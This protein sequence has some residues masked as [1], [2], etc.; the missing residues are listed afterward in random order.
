MARLAPQLLGESAD[1]VREF[2]RGRVDASGGFMDRDDTADL[3]Y[4]VFGLEG[5]QALGSAPPVERVDAYLR[6]LGDGEGFDLVNLASLARAWAALG[7]EIPRDLSANLRARLDEQRR[8]GSGW[9]LEA[10]E[11][12][13]SVYSTFLAIGAYQDLGWPIEEPMAVADF[14]ASSALPD[15]GYANE[16]GQGVATT[17]T[18]VAA[19]IA[20]LQLGAAASP[21]SGRWLR[22]RR[23]R[24]GGFLASVDAPM[25]DLLS[26]AVTLH[27]LSALEIDISPLVEPALDFVDSLWTARGGFYGHWADEE[28]DCE[29]TFYGLLA[30]GHLSVYVD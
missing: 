2:L 23:H 7:T 13:A 17:P 19:V 10:G 9:A 12:S 21:R 29:Y 16:P 4:T 22:A 6:T 3:Y 15:G 26:T 27:A 20:L 30:L 11:R 8:D 18:T 14:I 28:L 24:Q 1:L 5:F 25:P